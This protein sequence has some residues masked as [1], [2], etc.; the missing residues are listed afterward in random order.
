MN[1]KG[2]F[3]VLSDGEMQIKTILRSHLTPS[4]MAKII[5]AGKGVEQREHSY[6][7]GGH[8]DLHKHFGGHYGDFSKQQ[9]PRFPS[10]RTG[11]LLKY[12]GQEVGRE[13]YGEQG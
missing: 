13:G 12:R 1:G 10:T 7:A 9:Q 8:A 3:K 6:T 4:R 5:Q 11:G 2:M